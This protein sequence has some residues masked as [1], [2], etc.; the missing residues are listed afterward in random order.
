M[1]IL[2]SPSETKK[3]DIGNLEFR[4]DNLLFGLNVRYEFI[5][6]YDEFLQN[7][8]FEDISKFFDI[9][10]IDDIKRFKN[11]YN[12]KFGIKAVSRYTGVAYDALD[13][14]NLTAKSQNFIDKSTL[15]FSNLY[16][17]LRADDIIPEYKFKQGASFFSLKPEI[18]Y[19]KTL[20]S[21]LDEY[22]NS[23]DILDL[24]AVFY[25][26]FYTINTHYTTLKFIKDKKVISHWAKHYRGIVLKEIAKAN[27]NDISD[28]LDLKIENL[29]IY[30]IK[31]IGKKTEI[32][33]N[34]S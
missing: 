28:F 5:K 3:V 1:K 10:K 6:K 18:Y 11:S 21:S 4:L 33:Y 26:K 15:I 32:T 25:D 7:S 24:R 19:S 23:D 22:I 13:Y 9:K 30:E 31:K 8:S 12:A 20:K 27:I 34:I 14:Q 16:G 29:H 17:V 2:F